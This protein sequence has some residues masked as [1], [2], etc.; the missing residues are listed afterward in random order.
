MELK[1]YLTNIIF[2]CLPLLMFSQ[3]T[4]TENKGQ[5]DETILFKSEFSGGN[6]Y[7]EN[8]QLNFNFYDFEHLNHLVGHHH[9]LS[10]YHEETEWDVKAHCLLMTFKGAQKP[11]SVTTSG[12]QQEY[13]NYF[14]GKNP[15][16][17]ASKVNTFSSVNLENIY[18]GIDLALTGKSNSYKYDF[19]VNPGAEV[20]KIKIQYKG[21]DKIYLE[22]NGNLVVKTSLNTITEQAPYAYQQIKGETVKIECYYELKGTEVTFVF[23][24]GYNKNIP[25]IIDPF[26][27]FSRY[28]SSTANN[29]GY[30]AT[31]DSEENAYGAGSVFGI[32]YRTTPGAY[33][34]N[35]NGGT[36]DV[37]ITKYSPNGLTRIFSTYLGGNETELPHSLVVNSRDELYV[38]GTTSSTNFPTTANAIDT[39]YNGGQFAN[40]SNGLGVNYNNGSDIFVSRFS[41]D[42]SSLLASTLLGGSANDGL[43]TSYNFLHYNYAD[44]IRG[45]VLIDKNDNC[46]IVTCTFSTDFPIVNGFQNT[47]AGGLDGI[48]VKMDENLSQIL[49]SSYLG[50]SS[51]DA[52][53]SVTFDSTQNLIV[54]GGTRS[55]NFP[56]QNALQSNYQGGRADG[57]I[58]KIHQS[59]SGILHS[60]YYGTN[61]YDQ[62]YFVDVNNDDEVYIFGQTTGSSGALVQNAAYNRPLGGQLLSKFNSTVDSVI[63]ST[64]FGDQSGIPDIS[65]TAFLVDVCN[66]VFL[67]GWGGTGLG[68]INSISGTN[69]LDVTPDALDNT[70]DNRDFYFMVLRDDASDLIYGSFFGGNLSSE[71]VDGGTSR[72]DKKGVVYQAVCAGCGNNQDFPTV[73]T[74]SVGVWTN[75]SSC[76]LGVVKYAFTPPSIIADFSLPPVNCVPVNLTFTN[77]SQ[78]AFNDTSASAFFW[79]VNDSMIQSYNLNYLFEEPGIYTIKLV[80]I[81]SNSCN[82]ADSI[83]RQITIIGNGFNTLNPVAT[84]FG[85]SVQIGITPINSPNV[86]YNWTPSVFLNNPNISNPLASPTENITYTL[87]ISNQ[88]CFDTIVQPVI[89]FNDTV[90]LSARD[91]VCANDTVTVTS[92]AVLGGIYNWSPENMVVSGQ[93][94]RNAVFRLTEPTIIFVSAVNSSGCVAGN[95]IFID[96]ITDLPDIQASADPDTIDFGESSQ[97]LATSIDT[98]IFMWNENTTL[99]ATNIA[100]PV[101]SPRNTTTYTVRVDDGTCPNFADVTVFVRLAPC[102]EG[103]IFVPNAFTPNNDG[104]NDIFFVRSSLDIEGFKF[105][106][107]DRWGQ[108]MFQT[109][110]INEGWDG[111]FKGEPQSPSV[112]GW[113]C[114]GICPNGEPFF[115]KGNV[116]L[117]R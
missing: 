23:P 65:P 109:T 7:I 52:I 64:R 30:T 87:I 81:D 75:N 114:E 56:V 84:C 57:F 111:K 15:D 86:S 89:I 42:G 71:H 39:S 73:P 117:I 95:S 9:K 12:K 6:L 74:D 28:S 50:G 26:I 90:D 96:V 21:A 107:Y 80:A 78:T 1:T 108:A 32:G 102:I 45:E 20:S 29:F 59:G 97:L 68:G 106:V 16:K 38:F 35:F 14:L 22:Q 13:F 66:Q 17:W 103:R 58:A 61:S 27:V 76:N 77:Q 53:F 36:A 11:T 5:W 31:Y 4:F 33:N 82:F 51:D 99:S 110:N 115:L 83:T 10:H 41:A 92:T 88:N 44:E 94:T 49:W 112:Y 70:T 100:N 46:Y 93:G 91:L 98:D 72:F 54:S 34:V 104:N 62:I 2:F 101:V 18:P 69:G 47:N 3:L 37:A 63:W 8:N 40:F 79:Y 43:N 85:N 55:L 25:L 105:A 60:T 24:K 19:I 113:Y 48:I 67:S 116:T